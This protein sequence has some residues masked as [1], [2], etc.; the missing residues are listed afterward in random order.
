MSSDGRRGRADTARGAL[1]AAARAAHLA[2]G[3]VAEDSEETYLQKLERQLAVERLLIKMGEALKDVPDEILIAID[4]ALPWKGP[5]RLRDVASHWY[6]EGLDHRLIWRTLQVDLPPMI[7]AI[8][9]WLS[10]T[11]ND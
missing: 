8:E 10:R 3:L 9:S 7:A 6:T 4:P 5:K 1:A 2:R 11:P